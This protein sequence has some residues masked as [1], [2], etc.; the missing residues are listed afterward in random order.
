MMGT[1]DADVRLVDG[2]S[3][4]AGGSSAFV[5]FASAAAADTVTGHPVTAQ[6]GPQIY[7]GGSLEGLFKGGGLVGGF[8]AGFLG[9]GLLGLLF[10]RGLIGG[11]DGVPSYFGLLFQLALLVLLCRLIWTRWRSRDTVRAGALSPRQLAENY[12][13]S[14]DDLHSLGVPES[15]N[16]EIEADSPP[17]AGSAELMPRRNGRA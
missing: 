6:V 9:S 3:L 13:R 10:G 2:L 12:F 16:G 11:L 14:R 17:N 15:E 4:G 1:D 5:L 7:P 8:A